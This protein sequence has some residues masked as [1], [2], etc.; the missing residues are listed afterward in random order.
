[1]KNLLLGS[2]DYPDQ[3]RHI[4]RVGAGKTAAH[5]PDISCVCRNLWVERT[6]ICPLMQQSSD[7][8]V[9]ETESYN[10]THKDDSYFQ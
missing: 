6:P 10:M 1:M 9:E 8:V 7:K 3:T 4:G 5:A 2:T